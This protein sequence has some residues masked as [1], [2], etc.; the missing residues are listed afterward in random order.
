MEARCVTCK[1]RG[2]QETYLQTVLQLLFPHFPSITPTPGCLSCRETNPTVDG[3]PG[4]A[5][6]A[7]LVTFLP[8][9]QFTSPCLENLRGSFQED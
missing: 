6:Q 5:G 8:A 1:E 9:L 4:G 2:L 3:I 7:L